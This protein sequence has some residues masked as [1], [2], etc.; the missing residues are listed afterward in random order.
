MTIFPQWVQ[1]FTEFRRRILFFRINFTEQTHTTMKLLQHYLLPS[2]SLV[3]L[4]AFLFMNFTTDNV[5]APAKD[6]TIMMALLLDTSNSMD[7]LIDQAKSQLW[8]IVNELHEA[9][10]GDGYR[11]VIK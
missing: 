8:K 7:G 9:K 6:Q 11:P 1:P 4:V 5:D 3:F 10:W 2:R